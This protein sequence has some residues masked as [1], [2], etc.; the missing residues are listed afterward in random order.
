MPT[1]RDAIERLSVTADVGHA[2]GYEENADIRT[3]TDVI[4]VIFKGF[5][6]IFR[7]F[8]VEHG[9]R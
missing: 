6:C 9:Q 7:L 3:G 1:P 4:T 2:P 5:A 8:K